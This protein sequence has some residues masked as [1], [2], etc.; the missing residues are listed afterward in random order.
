M[1]VNFL[2][3]F[4]SQERETAE[5][6]GMSG[7][8]GAE[9]EA[10]AARSAAARKK[11]VGATGKGGAQ[12]RL[13]GQ[14]SKMRLNKKP[15]KQ[16]Q[17]S[18]QKQMSTGDKSTMLE[19][20]MKSMMAMKRRQDKEVQMMMDFEKMQLERRLE[21]EARTRGSDSARRV[22]LLF[23]L[24]AARAC[25]AMDHCTVAGILIPAYCFCNYSIV[26]GQAAARRREGRQAAAG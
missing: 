24:F 12:S 6:L 22:L 25:T 26:A 13:M 18:P 1:I 3:E 14:Q 16:G 4:E 9:G 17:E 20:E 2:N 10:L 19:M 8:L 7:Q 15:T 5:L 23:R 21:E 11:A